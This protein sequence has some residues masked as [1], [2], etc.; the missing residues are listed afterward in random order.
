MAKNLTAA[1]E[2][3]G[4]VRLLQSNHY[5]SSLQQDG[6][7]GLTSQHSLFRVLGTDH[8]RNPTEIRHAFFWCR[9]HILSWNLS[10]SR[11]IWLSG[12]DLKLHSTFVP[13]TKQ[14][15]VLWILWKECTFRLT[16]PQTAHSKYATWGFR[17]L[18][19]M[20]KLSIQPNSRSQFFHYLVWY[21]IPQLCQIHRNLL[22][23]QNHILQLFLWLSLQVVFNLWV[24]TG[25]KVIELWWCKDTFFTVFLGGK[26]SFIFLYKYL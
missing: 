15:R 11:N 4:I 20:K 17:N 1:A 2:S 21:I 18:L 8:Q 16:I 6:R 23:L 26:D 22:F 7:L 12:W 5:P 10:A 24:G 3:D 14:L 9:H 25:V 19:S 13:N